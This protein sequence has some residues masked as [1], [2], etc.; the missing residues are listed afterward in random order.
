L[1]ELVQCFYELPEIRKYYITS[2][3]SMIW[4]VHCMSTYMMVIFLVVREL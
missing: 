2:G 3:T 1:Q 4:D